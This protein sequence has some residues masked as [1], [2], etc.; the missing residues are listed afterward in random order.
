MTLAVTAAAVR[1]ITK[2]RIRVVSLLKYCDSR[3]TLERRA[4]L[5][6]D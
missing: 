4:R 5:G 6:K 3:I 2:Q 1:R